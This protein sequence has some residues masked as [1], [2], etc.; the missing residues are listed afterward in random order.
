M[1]GSNEMKV[2]GNLGAKCR[3]N[4]SF[5]QIL[6]LEFYGRMKCGEEFRWYIDEGEILSIEEISKKPVVIDNRRWI[7]Y[8]RISGGYILIFSG[9]GYNITIPDSDFESG[10]EH[11]I[12]LLESEF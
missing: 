12:N 6:P 10:Y 8:K 5:N 11:L 7:T 9:M 1:K 2:N 4:M 3:W